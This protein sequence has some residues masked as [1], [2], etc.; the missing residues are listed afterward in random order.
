[1]QIFRHKTK[2]MKFVVECR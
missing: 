1:M 2:H